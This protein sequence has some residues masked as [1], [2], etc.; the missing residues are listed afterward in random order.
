MGTRTVSLEEVREKFLQF[1]KENHPEV[2]CN[3]A[4]GLLYWL[5]NQGYQIHKPITEEI[6]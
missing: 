5:H 1:M 6:S 3:E 4:L 2:C